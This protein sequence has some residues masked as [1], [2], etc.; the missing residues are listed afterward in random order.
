MTNDAQDQI[1][2]E[3]STELKLLTSAVIMKLGG[4]FH[5]VSLTDEKSKIAKILNTE[6]FIRF[7]LLIPKSFEQEAFFASEKNRNVSKYARKVL[8][9]TLSAIRKELNDIIEYRFLECNLQYTG[10]SISPFGFTLEIPK[11]RLVSVKLRK[12]AVEIIASLSLNELKKHALCS[13][14]KNTSIPSDLVFAA[15]RRR[16][17]IAESLAIPHNEYDLDEIE[18]QLDNVIKALQK[19]REEALIAS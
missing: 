3:I 14:D 5:E 8:N 10:F 1:A 18:D 13:T 19:N 16:R 2:E 11:N 15:L 4:V 17:D 9:S 7:S 12:I 6:N